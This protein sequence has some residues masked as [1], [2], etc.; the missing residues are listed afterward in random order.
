MANASLLIK[1]G[2]RLGPGK[3]AALRMNPRNWH[4][5]ID[6]PQRLLRHVAA[7]VRLDHDAIGLVRTVSGDAFSG[8]FLRREFPAQIV[9]NVSPVIVTNRRDDNSSFVRILARSRR[10]IDGNDDAL[11]PWLPA[12]RQARGIDHMQIPQGAV[13]F[14]QDFGVQLLPTLARS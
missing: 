14:V 8:P 11:E 12:L 2:N 3:L 5:A 9:N 13:D 10:R 1:A 6:G 7:H 4:I